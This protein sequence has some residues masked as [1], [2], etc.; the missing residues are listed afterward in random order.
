MK[1][2]AAASVVSISVMV[3]SWKPD[4]ALEILETETREKRGGG[5]FTFFHINFGRKVEKDL[6]SMITK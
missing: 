3:Y 2:K 1:H 5:E 6:M 4:F